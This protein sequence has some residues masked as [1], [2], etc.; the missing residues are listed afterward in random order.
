MMDAVITI[1]KV[2]MLAAGAYI[3]FLVLQ[4]VSEVPRE[5]KRIANS[6]ERI[7]ENSE[8]VESDA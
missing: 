1:I 6:L 2:G 4:F 3:L 8:R 5:L 7:A